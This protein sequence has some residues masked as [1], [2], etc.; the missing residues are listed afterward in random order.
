MDKIR[1][2]FGRKRPGLFRVVSSH[3]LEFQTWPPKH[4]EIVK[5]SLVRD[6]SLQTDAKSKVKNIN[7]SERERFNEAVQVHTARARSDIDEKKLGLA[8]A[9]ILSSAALS[10][11]VHANTK[12]NLLFPRT[13]QV[14]DEVNRRLHGVP[15]K[16]GQLVG[17]VAEKYETYGLGI[18]FKKGS[19]KKKHTEKYSVYRSRQLVEP[20]IICNHCHEIE[21][22]RGKG[23]SEPS[24]DCLVSGP[25]YRL[26]MYDAEGRILAARMQGNRDV[27]APSTSETLSHCIP[28]L[29]PLS[30]WPPQASVRNLTF[31]DAKD[32]HQHL[33]KTHEGRE[34]Q[35]SHK[36]N[37]DPTKTLACISFTFPE[38]Q[39]L[40]TVAGFRIYTCKSIVEN[41]TTI[42]EKWKKKVPLCD[43]NG[44]ISSSHHVKFDIGSSKARM[45]TIFIDEAVIDP[46]HTYILVY[47]VGDKFQSGDGLLVQDTEPAFLNIKSAGQRTSEGDV[48]LMLKMLGNS[49]ASDVT[50]EMKDNPALLKNTA[51]N[52]LMNWTTS[53]HE[54]SKASG[55]LCVPAEYELSFQEVFEERKKVAKYVEKKIKN[56]QAKAFNDPSLSKGSIKELHSLIMYGFALFFGKNLKVLKEPDTFWEKMRQTYFN[57]LER[58][59]LRLTQSLSYKKMKKLKKNERRTKRYLKSWCSELLKELSDL[60]STRISHKK[61]QIMYHKIFERFNNNFIL[62]KVQEEFKCVLEKNDAFELIEDVQYFIQREMEGK[63]L[64]DAE[65]LVLDVAIIASSERNNFFGA[66][67]EK[68]DKIEVGVGETKGDGKVNDE[69]E[70][71]KSDRDDQG[72]HDADE[73]QK[74]D[75]E[76]KNDKDEEETSVEKKKNQDERKE[77]KTKDGK[78]IESAKNKGNQPEEKK[79]EKEKKKKEKVKKKKKKAKKKKAKKKKEIRKKEE[80]SENIDEEM[81]PIQKSKP[82]GKALHKFRNGP[83]RPRR[84]TAFLQSVVRHYQRKASIENSLKEALSAAREKAEVSGKLE[85]DDKEKTEKMIE[86]DFVNTH[87]NILKTILS[88]QKN[89]YEERKRKSEFLDS[90][91]EKQK[92]LLEIEDFTRS[93]TA[94]EPIHSAV[95][96]NA[97]RMMLV[98][99]GHFDDRKRIKNQL[100]EE[101][102]NR[103]SIPVASMHCSCS[104]CGRPINITTAHEIVETGSTLQPGVHCIGHP[105]FNAVFRYDGDAGLRTGADEEIA[106]KSKKTSLTNFENSTGMEHYE[107]VKTKIQN[108]WEN[109][110][111]K[112]AFSIQSEL[113]EMNEIHDIAKK[114][115]IHHKCFSG[116]SLVSFLRSSKMTKILTKIYGAHR[117][118]QFLNLEYIQNR[119]EKIDKNYNAL[120]HS[121]K[122]DIRDQVFSRE[123]YD[124]ILLKRKIFKRRLKKAKEDMLKISLGV[125]NERENLESYRKGK[126]KS[127]KKKKRESLFDVGFEN[128]ELQIIVLENTIKAVE[129]DLEVAKTNLEKIETMKSQFETKIEEQGCFV[130]TNQAAVIIAD[131]LL[132]LGIIEEVSQRLSSFVAT[133]TIFR[134]STL[135]LVDR[136]VHQNF[137]LS[138]PLPHPKEELINGAFILINVIVKDLL[139]VWLE[140]C[141]V[142]QDRSTI[143]NRAVGAFPLHIE[144][145]MQRQPTLK[146]GNVH[147]L[148]KAD[149]SKLPAFCYSYTKTS[150]S[151]S[152]DINTGRV[153]K[154][155]L[156]DEKINFFTVEI[157]HGYHVQTL[158][159]WAPCDSKGESLTESSLKIMLQLA[160]SRLQR[161]T[162]NIAIDENNIKA[163]CNISQSK[164][165]K[166]LEEE[167]KFLDSIHEAD[168]MLGMKDEDT[169]PCTDTINEYSAPLD[170]IKSD[171]AIRAGDSGSRSRSTPEQLLLQKR[172]RAQDHN[173]SRERHQ[174]FESR[175][176]EEIK[177]DDKGN[178]ASAGDNYY[179]ANDIVQRIFNAV[180]MADRPLLR[181]LL[182]KFYL[183]KLYGKNVTHKI[184]RRNRNS[185][186]P[187]LH[188]AASAG[189]D[190]NCAKLLLEE[191]D[192]PVDLRDNNGSTPLAIACVNHHVELVKLFLSHNANVSAKNNNGYTPLHVTALKEGSSKLACEITSLLLEKGASV[193]LWK[194]A[195][196]DLPIEIASASRNKTLEKLLRS[197][198]KG[199]RG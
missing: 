37:E 38:S 99:D 182:E 179:N 164:K 31:I 26:P 109:I 7:K 52:A 120:S 149:Q 73:K 58:N 131:S 18:V 95:K 143:I 178:N 197:K 97:V 66:H 158:A 123:T 119:L 87:H 172:S 1:R 132:R 23:N 106:K 181:I 22:N 80:R 157:L 142:D 5:F 183:P 16:R 92:V 166:S 35:A 116:A 124:A 43:L 42:E 13:R 51:Y 110:L 152:E 114:G 70:E 67:E 121:K 190:I 25:L 10:N 144:K 81:D 146:I 105:G 8:T 155:S 184:K 160:A 84:A 167:T 88:D 108:D 77:T 62:A 170:L 50:E 89:A 2:A 195:N 12:L 98:N 135:A 24:S 191:Y 85:E 14:G 141:D 133:G 102:R 65:T 192:T 139:D 34:N 163:E 15:I 57:R 3:D 27:I 9:E 86:E 82:I 6:Q 127:K 103:L 55:V 101:L 4:D 100:P 21:I 175:R 168:I 122:A 61:M 140:K 104:Q 162:N 154:S 188:F 137:M 53:L 39:S 47:T 83:K 185:M 193:D 150:F 69:N 59:E 186:Q 117:I 196:G 147:P 93:D 199:G 169:M 112:L 118:Y 63:T 17:L 159:F 46:T 126:K 60:K 79:E 165:E 113:L 189:P 130:L 45:C 20:N 32:I 96:K 40:W 198:M 78:M 174:E 29:V 180:E 128:E 36:N 71:K 74:I 11:N 173:E 171:L 115:V 90:C 176:K 48:L 148:T 49:A 76:K 28:S 187:L 54:I 194:S 138:L 75:E 19:L 64:N 156:Y 41:V 153:S 134:F 94:P 44:D 107:N 145:C 72:T 125:E 56:S 161:T 177:T 33:R 136:N 30:E 68:R 129:K 91:K 151:E 111:F